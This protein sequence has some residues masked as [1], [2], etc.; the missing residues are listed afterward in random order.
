MATKEDQFTD[1][2]DF[3]FF[4]GTWNVNGQ[5]PDGEYYN[6]ITFSRIVCGCKIRI[7]QLYAKGPC[8]Y[9]SPWGRQESSNSQ[10]TFAHI[11]EPKHVHN[12]N[13]SIRG[14]N[15]EH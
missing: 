15:M 3:S 9:E 14:E 1:A 10:P 13:V 7:R 4:V 11:Q 2:Q 12:H 5:S 6:L 8:E